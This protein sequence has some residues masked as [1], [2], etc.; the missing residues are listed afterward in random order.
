MNTSRKKDFI[1][2]A[3]NLFDRFGQEGV[4]IE[5]CGCYKYFKS[6]EEAEDWGRKYKIYTYQAIQEKNKLILKPQ[7]DF[8]L[9]ALYSHY[10]RSMVSLTP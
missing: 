10:P 2:L 9:I 3:K 8:K 4:V 1:R 7:F 6:L 5:Y